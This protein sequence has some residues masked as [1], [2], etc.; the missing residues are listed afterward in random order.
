[1]TDDLERQ[2]NLRNVPPPS[3]DLAERIIARAYHVPQKTPF[4]L[5]AWVRELSAELHVTRPAYTFASLLV[6]G[7]VVGISTA[8]TA[9]ATSDLSFNDVRY[10]LN[11][12]ESAL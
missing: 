4:N 2:L 8:Q 3:S 1:M 9:P 12:E 7:F 10:V 5:L 6:L 11:S